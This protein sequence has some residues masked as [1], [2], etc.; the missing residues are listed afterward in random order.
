M[1]KVVW[2]RTSHIYDIALNCFFFFLWNKGKLHG[3]IFMI[4][5]FVSVK[6]YL[7]IQ[8]KTIT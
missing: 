1:A 5:A 6:L 2:Q 8:E 3:S 4:L 7:T